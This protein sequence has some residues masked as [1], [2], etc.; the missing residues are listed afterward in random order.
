MNENSF[1]TL[2]TAILGLK[3]DPTTMRDWQHSSREHKEV[4]QCSDVLDFTD[5]QERD[6]ENSLHDFVKKC[7]QASYPD[8][9]MTKSYTARVEDKVRKTTIHCVCAR[10]SLFDC[11]T[12]EWLLSRTVVCASIARSQDILR[13][14]ALPSR[15]AD[16]RIIPCST[17]I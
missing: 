10:I 5:L 13:R 9:R 14:N 1:E 2:F 4:P 15:N 17:R 3:M 6:S 12:K 8:K 7:P 16:Y 11:P